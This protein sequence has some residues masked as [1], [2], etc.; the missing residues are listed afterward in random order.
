MRGQSPKHNKNER[1]PG[2][3]STI[4]ETQRSFPSP[5]NSIGKMERIPRSRHRHRHRF[6]WHVPPSVSCQSHWPELSAVGWKWDFTN[7]WDG[8]SR[9]NG[10]LWYI[11]MYILWYI[12]W[13]VLGCLRFLTYPT[14]QWDFRRNSNVMRVMFQLQAWCSR[15]KTQI[16]YEIH[17]PDTVN[18]PKM[19]YLF[20]KAPILLAITRRVSKTYQMIW[21][22][23]ILPRDS[24]WAATTI[25]EIKWMSAWHIHT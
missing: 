24:Q 15:I 18:P 8:M 6:Q 9:D 25:G 16:C 12:F 17:K 4:S 10:L 13:N 5:L 22:M 7:R 20:R 23:G 14:I 3:I 2:P 11:Y 21:E 19:E 1:K